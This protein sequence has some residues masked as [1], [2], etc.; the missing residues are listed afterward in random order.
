MAFFFFFFPSKRMPGRHRL[1]P[2]LRCILE[3][4]QACN[5]FFLL[6]LFDCLNPFSYGLP[7]LGMHIYIY[8][9]EGI[10]LLCYGIVSTQ[11]PRRR[12]FLAARG[13]R[14]NWIKQG[15]GA[16]H[17]VVISEMDPR[18]RECNTRLLLCGEQFQS[19]SDVRPY[20]PLAP[21]QTLSPDMTRV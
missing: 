6:P 13:L 16:C 12:F 10:T 8:V 20:E 17:L 7:C 15:P 1:H 2:M 5:V 21:A 18:P 9:G 3:D 4:R 11:N 19:I 14:G